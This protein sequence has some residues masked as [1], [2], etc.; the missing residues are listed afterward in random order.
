MIFLDYSLYAV[1][2]ECKTKRCCVCALLFLTSYLH[3]FPC[4]ICAYCT[5]PYRVVHL[6][7]CLSTGSHI[8][9]WGIMSNLCVPCRRNCILGSHRHI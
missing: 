7:Q 8:A 5:D 3:A 9:P 2:K 4:N 1:G 6:G